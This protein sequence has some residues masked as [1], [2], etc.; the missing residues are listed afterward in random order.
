MIIRVQKPQNIQAEPSLIVSVESRKGGVGKT[1]AALC[2]ARLLLRRGYSVLVL[3][4]DVTGT[5]AS[6][7]AASPFWKEDL[8]VIKDV[9]IENPQPVNL[10]TLFEQSFMTGNRVSQFSVQSTE[11][12]SMQIDLSKVNVMGSQIYKI[13]KFNNKK[14]ITCIERPGILFDDLHTFWLLEFIKQV[15]N[16]FVRSTRNADSAFSERV[17]IILD[18]SPG[19]VGIAP[20]IHEWLTDRGPTNGKF[21]TVTS[22]DVQD[23]LAC[24]MSLR[25]LHGLYEGKW[26]TSRLFE[27]ASKGGDR[28]SVGKEQESFFMRLATS[29]NENIVGGES[30]SFYK[31]VSIS[32]QIGAEFCINP[33][34]YSALILNR[35]PRAIKTGNLEYEFPTGIVGEDGTLQQ[36]FGGG[37]IKNECR[38]RMISYDEYIENQFLP[39][40]LQ[41]GRKRSERQLQKLIKYLDSAENELC[42]ETKESHEIFTFSQKGFGRLEVLTERLSKTNVILARARSALEVAGLGHLARLI[43]DEWLPG[44]ILP[45]FKSSLSKLMIELD[46]VPF[47]LGPFDFESEP[48]SKESHKFVMGFKRHILVEMQNLPI[49]QNIIEDSTVNVLASLLS[50]LAGLT[51]PSLSFKAPFHKEMTRL[52]AAVLAIELSHWP[53]RAAGYKPRFQRFLSHESA[54]VVDFKSETEIIANLFLRSSTMREWL[55]NFTNFYQACTYTQARLIDFLADSRFLIQLLSFIVRSERQ[56]GALFPY[57]RGIAEDIIVNKT[58]SHEEAPKRIEKALQSAEYFREFDTVLKNVLADWGVTHE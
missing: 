45:N 17:A 15:I 46:F 2:L 13:N 33:N 52:F 44:C 26:K 41:R 9:S 36:L 28:I 21:L 56:R 3:D 49:E 42:V 8:F 5:N 7:I 23:L 20:S 58:L 34:K 27:Q 24:E 29:S 53:K 38:K 55:P 47:D 12:A 1:T 22:L 18:N 10:L 14:G 57:V 40:S 48:A 43:Q 51:L 16:N 30:L 54:N 19:Y 50:V 39:Q 25:S 37:D 31:G 32:H 4:L 35:V 6:D 11:A